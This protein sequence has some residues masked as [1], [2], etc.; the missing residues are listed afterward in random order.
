MDFETELVDRGP[1]TPREAEVMRLACSAMSD[2]D[3]ARLLAISINTVSKH[4]EMIYEKI[5]IENRALNRRMSMIRVAIG[6]GM[7]RLLCLVLCTGAVVQDD[8]AMACR[9][10]VGRSVSSVRRFD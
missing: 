1:L 7:I 2:K 9:A 8:P 10:R 6:R 3:I 5:G 4:L